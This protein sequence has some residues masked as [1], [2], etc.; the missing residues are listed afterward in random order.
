MSQVYLLVSFRRHTADQQ[1]SVNYKMASSRF[2]VSGYYLFIL[3]FQVY[4]VT[5]KF[6]GKNGTVFF[7]HRIDFSQE[8]TRLNKRECGSNCWV[9]WPTCEADGRVILGAERSMCSGFG[10]MP[11]HQFCCDVSMLISIGYPEFLATL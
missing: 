6:S 2:N 9:D 4:H 3:L 11:G 10:A 1:T 7:G 5:C 8:L